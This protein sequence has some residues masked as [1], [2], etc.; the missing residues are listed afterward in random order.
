M[1]WG[2]LSDECG[3]SSYNFRVSFHSFVMTFPWF[4]DDFAWFRDDIV[5]FSLL[6]F[7]CAGT[8]LQ[9]FCML[10]AWLRDELCTV[11][12]VTFPR[13]GDDFPMMLALLHLVTENS[14]L[15]T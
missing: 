6:F 3:V 12:G 5:M 11:S 10:L 9:G 13:F 1:V 14:H 15:V 2:S 8:P 4:R 7:D